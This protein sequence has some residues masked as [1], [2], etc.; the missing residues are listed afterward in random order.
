MNTD[1]II[2]IL[3]VL[4][5]L[6]II[7][8]KV[9]QIIRHYP[10]QTKFV[11]LVY[12][13][14]STFET[15]KNKIPFTGIRITLLIIV[16]L[17]FL[18]ILLLIIE[19]LHIVKLK[20]SKLIQLLNPFE[21]VSKKKSKLNVNKGQQEINLLAILMGFTVAITVG[22]DFFNFFDPQPK[23]KPTINLFET[24]SIPI[25]F[26]CLITGFFLS[27]GSKFFH[28][29]LETIFQVKNLKQK[30]NDK[31]TYQFD[32]INQLDDWISKSPGDII[33][34]VMDKNKEALLKTDGVHGIS[35]GMI[36]TN[37]QN[38][39]GIIINASSRDNIDPSLLTYLLPNG[40][41]KTVP[42]KINETGIAKIHSINPP[43]KISNSNDIGTF[44][45]LCCSVKNGND[46]YMLTCYHVVKGKN[47]EWTKF[48]KNGY[49][50][51]DRK[52]TGKELGEIV[53]VRF[54]DYFDIALLKPYE[55]NDYESKMPQTA[56]NSVRHIY[57]Y[58]N[59]QVNILGARTKKV[60]TGKVDSL[61]ACQSIDYGNG[62]IFNKSDLICISNNN[63]PVSQPGDSGAL[64]YT[65]KGEAVGM[66]IAANDVQSFA[67][68]MYD[69]CKT[70]H[71]KF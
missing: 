2:Y 44:G 34:S 35:M 32:S 58:E 40:E 42:Y 26:G 65:D 46:I 55:G 53:Q 54:D 1:K 70:F 3:T 13:V 71:L 8:E 33:R 50:I 24:I 59:L 67:I 49:E 61:Y 69:I 38:E 14:Y 19:E 41:Q 47:H 18:L 64:V 56:I 17:S 52:D 62:N 28:D 16:A 23:L 5:I 27:F 51:I 6:S 39:L 68:P 31:S 43:L 25:I 37:G 7:N 29:L 22:A 30:L 48:E 4:F 9:V 36:S 66:I 20:N 12:L 45:T 10:L 60:M 11:A 57:S 15:F 21:Y 63:S